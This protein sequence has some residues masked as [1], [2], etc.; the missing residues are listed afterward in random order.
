MARAKSSKRDLERNRRLKAVA[1]QERRDTRNAAPNET[2]E[3]AGPSDVN[4]EAVLTALADLHARYADGDMSLDD[5]DDQKTE[6]VSQLRV[7]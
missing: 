2:P 1:K 5:F 3:A 7:E 4:Q 6:L